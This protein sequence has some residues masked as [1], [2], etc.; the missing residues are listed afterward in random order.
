VPAAAR[1]HDHGAPAGRLG[2]VHFDTSCAPAVQPE[3][4]RGVALLHSF[5]FSAAVESFT[6]VLKG[7]PR[8]TMAHWGVAMSWWGNP[9]GGF[10]GPAALAAGL[11]ATDAA[12]AIDAGTEREKAYV[13]A[14]AVLFRD[15]A[16]RDQRSRTVA[17]EQAMAA[18]AARYSEDAEARIFYALALGQTALPT[19]KS[20]ANQLKAAAILEQEFARQP[21]HPGLAHY[22][23][24]SFD[25]PPLASRGL[26]A[27]R[28]YAR[29]APDAP[30]ALHMP[31]HTFTRVGLWQDSI[32]TNLASAAAARKDPGAASEELHALDYQVYAY[33]QTAQD[34]AAAR[35]LPLTGPLALRIPNAGPGNAAPPS[36]GY[37][38]VAA[39]PARY[40]LER[41]AW[42]E[43]AALVPAQ[44]PFA[45]ADAV[46]HFA[47]A[48]GAARS[49]NPGAARQ[50]VARL[51]SLR[52]V[53]AGTKDGYWTEQVEIQRLAADAWVRLAE[54]RPVEAVALMREA[55]T[56][57]DATEK[58]A[59]T[60]GPIKPA[61]ELLGEML[62]Q[63][64]RPAEAL[65]EFEAT[66]TK[67]PNRFRALLGA[68]RAADGAGDRAK[69]VAHR[70][71][72]AAL[73]ARADRPGRAELRDLRSPAR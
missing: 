33:L 4:D 46:T 57:E 62:L 32:D 28:R 14:V 11:A 67:E 36:A 17:Y 2:A 61:R 53:V 45:W 35:T 15:P 3:F 44:T 31:S 29:I 39:I 60:P 10:R 58:A 9:F 69:A 34:A 20:Y 12:A 27:A 5:W 42:A 25:V 7:D 1:Q 63:L 73:T 59:L 51:A 52:D 70:A 47:R 30:H 48:I 64:D 21:T 56:R 8:C 65:A 66:L 54:G 49:G 13:A 55:A 23:I 6:T 18:L 37:Y 16:T 41:A 26:D 38:A 40:A 50:D 19:D 71:S 24:H 72:L 22:I 43:A 68:A